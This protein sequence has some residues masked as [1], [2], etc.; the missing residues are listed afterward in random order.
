MTEALAQD[1][2]T[3][4]NKTRQSNIERYVEN[5]IIKILLHATTTAAKDAD[6]VVDFLEQEIVWLFRRLW[7][8]SSVSSF[9]LE[10]I[11][12]TSIEWAI[13]SPLWKKAWS[14]FLARRVVFLQENLYIPIWNDQWLKA[15]GFSA[16]LLEEN[17]RSVRKILHGILWLMPEVYGNIAEKYTDELTWLGN[18]KLL[19][20]MI[21]NPPKDYA[22]VFIDIDWLKQ[23]NDTRWHEEWD[24]VIQSHAK[25]LKDAFGSAPKIF[26]RSG[27]EFILVISF[28]ESKQ[29][30]KKIMER[31]IVNM[32]T[33]IAAHRNNDV[34]MD[35]EI[36]FSLWI[37]HNEDGKNMND[38]IIRA[39]AAMYA[40][41]RAKK[42]RVLE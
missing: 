39:E 25:L 26:R 18:K 40:A 23:I 1:T 33:H 4:I 16:D 41:K 9:S 19:E 13:H 38:A 29:D 5:R 22:I 12:K 32:E 3:V 31:L 30:R 35:A 34:P 14:D 2:S 24:K 10:P 11:S 28:E 27:D 42:Q 15:S 8:L 21:K 6:S 37:A 17:E 20:R 36:P 7:I